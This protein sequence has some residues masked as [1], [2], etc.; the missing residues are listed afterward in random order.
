MVRT[1]RTFLLSLSL[2]LL[3]T[4][5]AQEGG[6]WEHYGGDD[7][8]QRYSTLTAINRDN[9]GEL[10]QAWVYRTG[11]LGEDFAR[12]DKLAFEATPILIDT[13]LYLSTPTNI[14]IAL[15][16]S[17]GK[18]RWRSDPRIDRKRRYAEAASRGV[19]AWHES[20]A[21]AAGV[22][23]L[24][25]F[26][27]TLDARLIAVDGRT[28]QLCQDF[29]PGG[30][31]D[32]ASGIRIRSAPD[33]LVTSPPAIYKDLVIVGAAIGDNRGVEL[34]RGVVRA[35]DARTGMLRWSWDPIPTDPAD[36]VSKEWN[37]RNA[38]RTGAA[39]AWSVMSVDPARGLLFVPTG[40]ASPDFY[41]GQRPGSNRYANSLVALNAGNGK[42]VW[43]RQLVHH[44]LW[45]YDVASQP[46]LAELVRD[47]KNVAAVIQATKMG[48]LFVFDRETGA[49]LFDIRERPVPRSDVPGEQSWPTQP[50]PVLPP[51]LV[52]HARVRPEDAW[53]LTFW[54]RGKCSDQIARLDSQ[55]IYTPP[56]LQGTILYPSYA[57]GS[58]WGGL[59]LDS[60]R[61]WAI[62]PL[63]N[64]PM[65]VTLIKADE[66]RAAAR[67]GDFPDS[68]FALQA[69][70]PYGMRREALL[71]QW[72]LPCTAPPWG[73]LAAVDLRR[74][75][76][77]WQVPLG[78]TRDLLPFF[79]PTRTLGTPHVGGPIV[80]AG[81][82]IFIGA[83]MDN[84]LRAFDVE[85]G[86]EL[87]KGRLPAG[88]QATP[89]TYYDNV[90]KRQL[91]V[92]AAGGHGGLGTKR[93]DYVVAFGLPDQKSSNRQAH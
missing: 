37:A 49:P 86:K 9:V 34:E 41:G 52:S 17:T 83:A 13:T 16:A 53:G 10:E 25:I 74:G 3:G 66:V 84:Y 15:D 39:N 42:V 29:G 31:V 26:M 56:S 7:F 72:G 1:P 67:S 88:G 57:G 64:L 85:T 59:A 91:V 30:E 28:G 90:E 92:I 33:Y 93:G 68:E 43:H 8:G 69:G 75:E 71:S 20:P 63:N 21:R 51:P 81:G 76:I 18:E 55:G 80:T 22:C 23:G 50:L 2:T 14:L 19:S 48:V 32:L 54:D 38:Q 82:L 40:S 35:F 60:E 45:D 65:V 70:T 4:T 78:S 87:W 47:G 62:V 44:D 58:N 11:E 73:T 12:A 27:G 36:P 77:K 6:D 24:R 46:V 5:V 89:M 61:Q 79:V